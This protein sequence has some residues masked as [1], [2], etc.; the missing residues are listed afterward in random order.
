VAAA[1]VHNVYAVVGAERFLRNDAI[2]QLVSQIGVDPDAYAPGGIRVEGPA[3]QLAEVLD[4]VRT[5][6]LLGGRKLV[7][8]DDAD[9]FIKDH[10]PALERYCANPVPQST[11]VLSCNS[12]PRNTK[13]YRAIAS[14]GAVIS[15]EPPKPWAI[16]GWISQR[17]R[18]KYAK[19]VTAPTAVRLREHVGD[20]LG[21]LDSELAKLSAYVGARDEITPADIDALTGHNREQKVFGITDAMALGDTAK[22]LALWE[23]VLATDRAA[24]G[25]ALA[26]LAW[27]V[28]RLLQA[29]RDYDKGVPARLLAKQLYMD[30][31]ALSRAMERFDAAQLQQQQRD[32]LAADVAIKTG[33][34]SPERAVEGFIVTHSASGG[35]AR[36]GRTG[37]T[38]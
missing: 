7:I 32:L 11:L 5:P 2:A 8:V 16:P 31:N 3:A 12:L 33:H 24:P 14:N 18:D 37:T 20:A 1:K 25:R 27:G 4:E 15:C 22:A 28:R 23:Q 34:S 21:I 35:V 10:R 9:Q 36:A 38:R 13:V 29:R 6:S 26:G 19:H 17:A 30:E